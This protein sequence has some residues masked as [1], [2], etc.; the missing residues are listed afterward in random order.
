MKSE[1]RHELQ[2]N[3]LS[4]GLAQTVDFC[5]RNANALSWGALGVAVLVLLAAL[6]YRYSSGQNEKLQYEFSTLVLMPQQEMK[7]EE[8]LD[9]LKD[10]AKRD[11]NEQRLA[12]VT[13]EIGREYAFRALVAPE[14]DRKALSD[15]ASSYFTQ[16]IQKYAKENLLVAK[17]HL[18]LAKLAETQGDFNTAQAQYQAVLNMASVSD[19]PVAVLAKEA[20]EAMEQFRQP[21]VFAT[22][23]PSTQPTTTSAPASASA[24][25]SGPATSAA[26]TSV[27]AKD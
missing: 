10:L 25:A 19:Y 16:V 2:E 12:A 7:P 24:P 11:S 21:I 1:R 26:T 13:Y 4:H 22:T 23:A 15:Q 9:K 27:P 18:G 20:R 6:W 5:R 17:A 8:R 3:I 14:I